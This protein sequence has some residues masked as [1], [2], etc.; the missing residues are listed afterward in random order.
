MTY[1]KKP[2]SLRSNFSKASL[3]AT[4]AVACAVSVMSVPAVA[5]EKSKLPTVVVEATEKDSGGE[6]PYANPAAPYKV[7]SMSSQKYSRPIAETPQS[8]TVIGKEAISDSGATDLNDVMRAQPGITLGTGEGGNAFG[9]RYIIRGF[10]ARNDVFVDGLRD[11]GVTTRELFA[12]EQI[13]VSKGP[14]SSFAGRGTTGGAINNVTKKPQDTDFTKVETTFGTDGKQRYTVDNNLV[15]ND[16]WAIR[17]NMLYGSRDIPGRDGADEQR[18][19]AAVAVEWKPKEEFKLNADYY[20]QA[21]DDTPDGGVPWDSVR[22]KPVEGSR[23]Y[24]QNGRDYLEASSN[25]ATLGLQYE[26]SDDFR[27]NNQTRY[28]VT[29]N[30]Y[31]ITI[32]GLASDSVVSGTP[33][34]VNTPGVYVRA[35]SQNRNQENTYYGNQTNFMLDTDIAGMKHSWVFGVEFSRE[36]AENLP[37]TDSLRSPNA[38]DPYNPNNDAWLIGGGSLTENTSRYAELEIDSQS[39]YLLDTWTINPT[40]ELFGGLRYDTFDYTV[41]SGATAYAGATDGAISNDDGFLNGH[42]GV[43]FSPWQNGNIYTSYSTSSNPTGE[44]L[45]AFTNCAYGGICQDATTGAF[46]KPELNQN[47]ELGTKWNLMN[48]QLLL[49]GALF[50]TTKENVV[51]SAGSGGTA[52]F[53]QVGEMRVRGVE[54]SFSGNITDKLSAQ[55]GVALLDT[56]I[57]KSDTPSEI[58]QDFPNTAETSANLQLRYQATDQWAFGWTMTYTGEISGGTPNAGTT[59]NT[60]DANAR[61]DLMTEYALTKEAKVKFNVLNVTDTEYYDAL[62]RSSAPFVYVGEGRSANVT[63]SYQF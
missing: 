52:T 40:W 9:D 23:Y 17:T 63:L 47:I 8:I 7:E 16:Q 33:I 35:S 42:F 37:F 26:F 49:T 12:V 10:E 6:N 14:S 46:P 2:V 19:G 5:K 22:G 30:E 45:D 60:I 62:Y 61:L 38:G 51:S 13:E 34:G 39:V 28:G 32:P 20:Y 29:T 55:A 31:L 1:V 41:N 25:I 36:E 3:G 44:Q 43:V 50:Q 27:V 24:G 4:A 21:S 58:G 18:Q 53:T 54:V 59:G 56:E 15:A 11:P 57:T 48:E